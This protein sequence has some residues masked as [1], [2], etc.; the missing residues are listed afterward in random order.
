MKQKRVINERE[1]KQLLNISDQ[2]FEHLIDRSGCPR[3]YHLG[4]LFFPRD[5]LLEWA[6]RGN[7]MVTK[8]L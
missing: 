2:E 6:A 8:D 7:D 3:I 4:Y 1:A 5:L